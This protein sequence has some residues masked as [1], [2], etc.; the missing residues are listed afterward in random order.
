MTSEQCCGGCRGNSK[1]GGPVQD[2]AIE[3]RQPASR[4]VS[5]VEF[6]RRMPTGGATVYLSPGPHYEPPVCRAAWA[7]ASVKPNTCLA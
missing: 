2:V 6:F 5:P 4:P 3:P 7:Y 1:D